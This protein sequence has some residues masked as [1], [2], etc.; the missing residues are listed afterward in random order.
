MMG[1]LLLQAVVKG[2]LSGLNILYLTKVA[3]IL[4]SYMMGLLLLQAC[5]NR[6][7]TGRW[8]KPSQNELSGEN[9]SKVSCGENPSPYFGACGENPS[10]YFQVCGENPSPYFQAC[11]ENPSTLYKALILEL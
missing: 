1:L 6:C 3:I 4:E 10:P 2:H 5:H 9:A 11:G 7:H 8:K